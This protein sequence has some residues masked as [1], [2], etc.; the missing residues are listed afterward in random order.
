MPLNPLTPLSPLSPLT[1]PAPDVAK[2]SR[3]R[4]AGRF[5]QRRATRRSPLDQLYLMGT[6]NPHRLR[7]LIGADGSGSMDGCA[8][9]RDAALTT[10]IQWAAVNLHA[11]DEIAVLDWAA[12]AKVRLRPTPLVQTT[13][14][15]PRPTRLDCS[16][17][18]LTPLLHTIGNLPP[19]DA[20]TA[21]VLLSDAQLAD[22]PPTSAAGQH[23]LE[24][25]EIDDLQLLVPG[26]DI[27]VPAQWNTAFPTADPQWFDG[28]DAHATSL[29]LARALASLTGQR[30]LR[31]EE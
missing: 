2:P 14:T 26:L 17:S 19:T 10:F 16:D 11:D 15:L 12:N 25:Q 22:L 23:T 4:I 30:L 21:L 3:S 24:A 5:A 6:R 1:H 18:R 13:G 29:A 20:R 9:A 31:D 28:S 27:Q 7:L 8:T